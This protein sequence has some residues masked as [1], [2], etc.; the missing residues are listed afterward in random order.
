MPGLAGRDHDDLL[1]DMIL[2][3]RPLPPDAPPGMHVLA[4]KLVGLAAAP[5]GGQLPGEAA[6]LAAF[7]RSACERL[8]DR[9]EPSKPTDNAGCQTEIHRRQIPKPRRIRCGRLRL[10]VAAGR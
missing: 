5:S 7:V 8:K 4:S 6:A 1:L 10:P 2:D 3:R 9:L